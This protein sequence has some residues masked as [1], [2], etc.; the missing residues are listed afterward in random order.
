MKNTKYNILIPFDFSESTIGLTNNI[1][2][3]TEKI[4][5]S[6]YIVFVN[7]NNSKLNANDVKV[8]LNNKELNESVDIKVINGKPGESIVSYAVDINAAVIFMPHVEDPE[9]KQ[10]HMGPV[11]LFVIEHSNCPVLILKNDVVPENIKTILLPLDLNAE[12]KLKISTA[13]FFTRFFKNAMICIVSAVFD[14]DDFSLNKTVYRMEHLTRF[15]AKS[16]VECIGEII[17]YGQ[18]ENEKNI[19]KAVIDY[20]ERSEAE[21]LLIMTGNEKDKNSYYNEQEALFMLS[22]AK[23]NVISINPNLKPV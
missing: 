11:S 18:E 17:R 21:I 12:N 6:L 23:N 8:K 19:G 2:H 1:I 5:A 16:G 13:I 7:E 9:N 14:V 20:A 22:H 10:N 3:L 15:I 4:N